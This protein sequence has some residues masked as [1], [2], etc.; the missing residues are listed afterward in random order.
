MVH[1]ENLLHLQD[2]LRELEIEFETMI[3]DVERYYMEQLRSGVELKPH[4]V[5]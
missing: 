5:V 3:E 2:L 1:A 4:R